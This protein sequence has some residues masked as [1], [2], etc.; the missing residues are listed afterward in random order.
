[1][2]TEPVPDGPA[3]MGAAARLAAGVC[4]VAASLLAAPGTSTPTLDLALGALTLGARRVDEFVLATSSRIQAVTDRAA[5]APLVG[6]AVGNAVTRVR[7]RR[8]TL[9]TAGAAER[10]AGRVRLLDLVLTAVERVDV[11]TVVDAIDINEIIT[12]LDLD[13]V[14]DRIDI[15]AVVEKVDIA[16]VVER[17]DVDDL[18][19]RTELGAIIAQSTSGVAST[20]LDAVRSQTVG[21]DG[22]TNRI[23]N[24][25]LRRRSVPEGPPLLVNPSPETPA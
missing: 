1:M 17:I 21:L 7:E 8:N 10:V 15:Q 9:A 2:N 3:P 5:A 23:V 22:F 12:H 13:A 18:I 6:T 20:A 19:S 14:I 25:T 24:R 4:D 16:A 11:G